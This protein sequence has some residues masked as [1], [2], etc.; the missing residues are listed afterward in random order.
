M[1]GRISDRPTVDE[2]RR[3][4]AMVV[5]NKKGLVLV[6]ERIDINEPSWQLPQG[7]IDKQETALMAANRELA[8]ELGTSAVTYLAE[9]KDWISYDIPSELKH[10]WFKGKFRGQC[11]KLI[12]FCYTGHDNDIRLNSKSPEFRDWKWVELEAL[13]DLIVLFKKVVYRM[14]VREF[15]RVRNKLRQEDLNS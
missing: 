4:V 6:A 14:A 11:V 13:P 15:T 10:E 12:A 1:T 2:Y 9:A 3:C 8:E 5:F 7:G